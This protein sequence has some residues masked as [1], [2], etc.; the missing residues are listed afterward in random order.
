MSLTQICA[1]GILA[2]ALTYVLRSCGAKGAAMVPL[3]GGLA[4]LFYA[5]SRYAAPIAA[6]RELAEGAGLGEPFSAV[7]R[8]LAVGC[9]CR[10]SGD[11]CRDMGEATLGALI[12]LCG[13]IE[14]LLLCLPLA[15]EL[16]RLATEVLS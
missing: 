10:L 3:T 2:A 8:M 9:L 5:L 1:L 12:E 6:L 13:R 4:L 14:I 15:E 11:L 16:I 7:L